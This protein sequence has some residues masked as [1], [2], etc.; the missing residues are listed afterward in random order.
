MAVYTPVC[1]LRLIR[2]AYAGRHL[3]AG[4]RQSLQEL[5]A[6]TG[7]RPVAS[8][9]A[10]LLGISLTP[11]NERQFWVAGSSTARLYTDVVEVNRPMVLDG[12]SAS[13]PAI[14][15]G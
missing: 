14:S 5:L 12:R 10:I 1:Y 13:G 9:R 3:K 15:R 4:P 2:F 7:R 8:R 11:D 6:G